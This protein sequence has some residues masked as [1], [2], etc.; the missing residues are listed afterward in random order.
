MLSIIRY[1]RLWQKQECD[2][3]ANGQTEEEECVSA[4]GNRRERQHRDLYVDCQSADP[5]D[6]QGEGVG[7]KK[8]QPTDNHGVTDSN[9][10]RFRETLELGR[11]V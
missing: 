5:S 9:P 10:V 6:V 2:I 1:P 4:K 11:L 3:G 8:I 7:Q